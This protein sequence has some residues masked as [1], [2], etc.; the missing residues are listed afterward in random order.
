[1]SLF[2]KYIFGDHGRYPANPLKIS[3]YGEPIVTIGIL[4][5]LSEF[6]A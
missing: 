1:M 3:F 5:A 2:A 4:Q 6:N